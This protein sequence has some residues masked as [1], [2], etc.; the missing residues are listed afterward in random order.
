[1][2]R[3]QI[4]NSQCS[5]RYQLWTNVFSSIFAIRFYK[6]IDCQNKLNEIY[7]E[8]LFSAFGNNSLNLFLDQE[9]VPQNGDQV[10]VLN[11]NNNRFQ[12]FE[13]LYTGE[14]YLVQYNNN[15]WNREEII[16]HI[17]HGKYQESRSYTF[18]YLTDES[19]EF[20]LDEQGN[21]I[22]VEN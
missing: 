8:Q 2:N 18:A 17:L 1:M 21:K 5:L 12:N 10:Y 19:G 6:L 14:R 11:T 16:I 22:I 13:T 15:M 4:I 9:T 7:D 3:E 20:V